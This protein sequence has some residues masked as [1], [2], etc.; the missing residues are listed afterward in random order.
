MLGSTSGFPEAITRFVECKCLLAGVT[1]SQGITLQSLHLQRY[2]RGVV[3]NVEEAPAPLP[4]AHAK[5]GDVAASSATA[6]LK[7]LMKV[8][9]AILHLSEV[10]TPRRVRISP[11]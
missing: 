5:I 4:S 7:Q 2:Y 6:F 10:P 8:K 11:I 1:T 9:C 3:R